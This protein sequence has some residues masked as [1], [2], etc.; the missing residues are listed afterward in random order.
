MC[1]LLL[2][3]GLLKA[4]IFHGVWA[5]WKR[6]DCYLPTSSFP[7]YPPKQASVHLTIKMQR[8]L[9]YV[10]NTYPHLKLPVL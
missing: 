10:P 8:M 4:N 9:T 6:K 3:Q 5:S 7:Q 2:E 1:S